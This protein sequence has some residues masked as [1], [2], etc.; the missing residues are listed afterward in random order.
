M[1]HSQGKEGYISVITVFI[2]YQYLQVALELHYFPTVPK[3]PWAPNLSCYPRSCLHTE[4]P[5]HIHSRM[6]YSFRHLYMNR[7]KNKQITCSHS[8]NQQA[9]PDKP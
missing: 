6:L 2:C 8:Y 9:D 3:Y 4:V 1:T 5:V 7:V